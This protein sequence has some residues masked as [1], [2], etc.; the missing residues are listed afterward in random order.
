MD[1]PVALILKVQCLSALPLFCH[2]YQLALWLWCYSGSS[3]VA[4]P[5]S[6]SSSCLTPPNW[7]E[8]LNRGHL[9]N[10]HH[11]KNWLLYLYMKLTK[12]RTRIA[13][14][15]WCVRRWIWSST[16]WETHWKGS[17]F[18]YS[19]ICCYKDKNCEQEEVMVLLLPCHKK[20]PQQVDAFPEPNPMG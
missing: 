6:L 19:M 16:G 3:V 4:S 20:S 12:S 14:A 13:A 18:Y 10:L 17:W 1:N 2:H 15:N 8:A 5:E 7:T 11:V 9:Q